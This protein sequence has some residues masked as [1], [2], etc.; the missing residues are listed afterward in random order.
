[1]ILLFTSAITSAFAECQRELKRLFLRN[2]FYKLT[3]MDC[4]TGSNNLLSNFSRERYFMKSSNLMIEIDKVIFMGIGLY[5]FYMCLCLCR[6]ILFTLVCTCLYLH[7]FTYSF[8][9]YR[10][11][12]D[13]LDCILYF[14]VPYHC[15]VMY[16]SLLYIQRRSCNN[17][18]KI[19]NNNNDDNNN[20]NNNNNNDNNNNIPFNP[21]IFR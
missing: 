12:G 9:F 14:E 19:N 21:A 8:R 5:I 6:Y 10:G 3:K 18:M 4:D 2:D 1:M 7:I 20:N 17:V 13:S 15:I 16:I 11:Q